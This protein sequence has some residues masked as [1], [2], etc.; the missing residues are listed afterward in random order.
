MDHAK[1]IPLVA[2]LILTCAGVRSVAQDV[3]L[4]SAV[5]TARK[6]L[7]RGNYL[8][9]IDSLKTAAVTANGKAGDPIAEQLWEQFSP[10]VTNELPPANYDPS[11]ADDMLGAGWKDQISRAS[12]RD[13]I[14]EIVRRARSTSIVILN[15]AHNSPRDRAFALQVARALR[16]LGYSVLAVE[17]IRNYPVAG[18]PLSGDERLKRDGFARMTTGDYTR[19]PVFAGFL[20]GAMSLG[21][22]PIAYEETRQQMR[23]GE[24]PAEREK[25]QAQNLFERVFAER[26]NAKTLIY[27]GLSHVAEKPVSGTERMAGILKR[28]TNVDPLTIDQA[29]VTDLSPEAAQAYE[30]AAAKIG[31]RS[32]V[33]FEDKK[34]LVLGLYESAVDLQVIHPRREY[35]LGRPTW[36]AALRGRPVAVPQSLRP[37][38][39]RRL[40]QI[41]PANAPADA[42]PYDQIII[43]AGK[44]A[45]VLLAPSVPFRFQTQQ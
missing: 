12:P 33:L 38:S 44:P 13:A 21:Y 26:P 22:D 24:R 36:L 7:G 45:P 43:T 4:P 40:V 16:P 5:E 1:A 25:A 31:N 3:F 32:A 42:V 35:H 19:D 11:G 14:P 15:E 28:L 30:M 8:R 29:T 41:F 23:P 20:R 27:V 37:A 39:G 2:A 9:A 17:A 18:D 6:D 34:P 10:F